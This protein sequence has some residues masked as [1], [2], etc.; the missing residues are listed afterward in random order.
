MWIIFTRYI[1]GHDGGYNGMAVVAPGAGRRL[2]TAGHVY[3]LT[4]C[5]HANI[6]PLEG[7]VAMDGVHYL[8]GYCW[9][10][11]PIQGSGR[12]PVVKTIAESLSQYGENMVYRTHLGDKGK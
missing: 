10:N 11:R 6:E 4:P 7:N 3:T 12:R 1:I 9:K 5:D 8:V 2:T